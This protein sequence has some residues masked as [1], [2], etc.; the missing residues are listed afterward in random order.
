M[1]KNKGKY[2]EAHSMNKKFGMGD[3]VGTGIKQPIGRVRDSY[4][5]KPLSSSKIKTP[6]KTLA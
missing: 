3:F 1:K 2:K 5:G 6:P 4:L